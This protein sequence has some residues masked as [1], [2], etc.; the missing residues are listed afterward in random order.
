MVE[1][2]FSL[3]QEA[4]QEL[5]IDQPVLNI[6]SHPDNDVELVGSSIKV[7]HVT[8]HLEDGFFRGILIDPEA[9]IRVDG[10]LI[11]DTQFKIEPSQS[12]KIGNYIIFIQAKSD[13]SGMRVMYYQE[14]GQDDWDETGSSSYQDRSIL[15]NPVSDEITIDVEQSAYFEC[16]L[17]NA[18]PI[19]ATFFLRVNGV[20]SEWVEITP[21][22]INL[23]EG[24]R[25]LVQVRVT[26]PRDSSS[27]AGI[28]PVRVV[29]ISPNYVGQ[30]D[31]AT[32]TLTIQPFYEFTL[33]NLSPRD[34]RIGWRKRSGVTYLPIIN[35]S[36]DS[37]E[38]N[39]LAM[40]DEN[41]CSFDFWISEELQLNRQATTRLDAGETTELPIQVTP[42]KIP[43]FSLRNKRYHY[44]TNVQIPQRASAPQALSGSATAVPLFG[45]WSIVLGVATLLLGLF[46]L[47]QPNIRSFDVAAGKDVIE[48]GDSTKLIWD[49]SPFAT[50]L[51]VSGVDTP[52][53]RGQVSLTVA[54]TQSTNYELVSG[55]WLSGMFGLDQKRTV[56]VLVVP[57]TPQVNVFEVDKTI[58]A[59]GTPINVRWSVIEADEALL[60]IDGVVYTLSKEEFSGEQQVVLEKDALVTLEAK[61]ASGSELLSYFVNV[62]PPFI[63]IRSFTVW[64]K[65]DGVAQDAGNFTVARSITV[66]PRVKLLPIPVEDQAPDPN[67]PVK[68]VE[69]VPEPTSET[70]YRVEFTGAVREELQ[71]GEQVILEWDVDGVDSLQ[72]SPF[73]EELPARGNQPFFP[74]ES[75]NFVMTAASGELEG[76]YMLPVKVFDGEPPKAPTIDFF[77]ASPASMVGPGEVE[78]SWSVSGEWTRVNLSNANGILADYLNPVGFKKLTIKESSTIILTAYN[79]TLSSAKDVQLT[80]DPALLPIGLYL[81]EDNLSSG[82]FDVNYDEDFVI[83][84]YDPVLTTNPTDPNTFVEPTVDPTGTVYVTDG[85]NVCEIK[86]PLKVCNLVFKTP[87]SPKNVTASYS[88]DSVYQSA[89]T[90]DAYS[91]I[92]ILSSSVTLSPT[93]YLGPTPTPGSTILPRDYNGFALDTVMTA[94]IKVTSLRAPLPD[95]PGEV[96]MYFCKQTG[97]SITNWALDRPTCTPQTYG[98]IDPVTKTATITLPPFPAVGKYAL[99]F[100]YNAAGFEPA[101]VVEFDVDVNPIGIYFSLDKCSDPIAWTGCEIG[102]SD[103]AKTIIEFDVYRTDPA[104]VRLSDQIVLPKKEAYEFSENLS[105]TIQP[106]NCEF[107]VTS[108]GGSNYRIYRC[109][110]NF[111]SPSVR[112]T[113]TVDF[114]FDPLKDP[115]YS[116]TPSTQ[117]MSIL[118]IKESTRVSF[119]GSVF[120]GLKVGQKIDFTP[121]NT[122]GK[123]VKL[124]LDNDPPTNIAPTSGA[125]TITSSV[126]NTF[127]GPATGAC[128]VSN[129]GKTV[130]ISTP[131]TNCN[132]SIYLNNVVSGTLSVAYAGNSQ[133]YKSVSDPTLPQAISVTQQDQLETNW[134]Y[135][136]LTSTSYVS[137]GALD[138]VVNDS[139]L[140]VRIELLLPANFEKASLTGLDMRIQL[141]GTAGSGCVLTSDQAGGIS[142]IHLPTTGNPYFDYV[143][144]CPASVVNKSVTMTASL[145]NNTTKFALKSGTVLARTLQVKDRSYT[146]MDVTFTRVNGSESIYSGSSMADLHFGEVYD[147][148]A[149]VGLV[150]GDDWLGSR[151]VVLDNLVNAGQYVNIKFSSN[152]F[153]QIDWSSTTCVNRNSA[154]ANTV[155]VL[156]NAYTVVNYWGVPDINQPGISDSHFYSTSPCKIV[157]NGPPN[158]EV[159]SGGTTTLSYAITFNKTVGPLSTKL[160]KQTV[161]F[162]ATPTNYTPFVDSP[163]KDFV[164]EFKPEIATTSKQPLQA[165]SQLAALMPSDCGNIAAA[166]SNLSSPTA[167]LTLTPQTPFPLTP[168]AGCLDVSSTYKILGS[169]TGNDYFQN[170]SFEIPIRVLKHN[171]DTKIEFKNTSGSWV[172]AGSLYPKNTALEFK[173]TVSRGADAFGSTP[174]PTGKVRVWLENAGVKLN[175]DATAPAGQI[176]YTIALVAGSVSYN[177]TN[178][179]YE[180]T[181]TGLESV[182]TLTVNK[183]FPN[184]NLVYQYVGDTYYFGK[185]IQETMSFQ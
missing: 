2:D 19:V 29:A 78:F 85:A 104:G 165:L 117:T 177:S 183:N 143:L 21:E 129:I 184:I 139:D 137:W 149:T 37:A 69:L 3:D 158:T 151:K 174:D 24:Q 99:L 41:G 4:V 32:L 114:A 152:I 118:I 159:L 131:T 51:S 115:N 135:K 178:N 147:V 12:L 88:G 55:N 93:F 11:R 128:S 141:S 35:Q 167:K 52:I 173:V 66:S 79:G 26:P 120:S 185:I 106:W 145:A 72:I 9:E 179:Y 170:G 112:T 116:V 155:G 164:L 50:R 48:L 153:N 34:Q 61:N 70:G 74:Q 63:N 76:I 46:I 80:V 136:P 47:L 94:D 14:Y 100:T 20:P 31:I 168:V 87:G 105:G 81:V 56:A 113:A 39:L 171:P 119:L 71:P 59:K 176:D 123:A 97:T 125:I 157:F 130:T 101:E 8:I 160:R 54:P 134:L 126:A 10:V 25:Q 107:V 75:M 142:D 110:A 124:T 103:R 92:S 15:I 89:S 28:H 150:Y 64:V 111:A 36:N 127:A 133:Y 86:L 90:L 95:P 42:H 140:P 60:T 161:N 84:F 108:S 96:K 43:M 146:F 53:S 83:R 132:G 23:N 16:E 18:G 27:S 166:F 7:F 1:R 138:S 22:T 73:T 172:P 82:F 154:S 5:I 33:G 122:A 180:I 65:P 121:V 77:K 57:P 109:E 102:T 6:G 68:F 62:I 182:F 58:V 17:I 67:F 163:P 175:G 49:V 38:F 44:T 13:F 30:R 40:D 144:R 169:Y 91:N 181:P 148:S 98:T 45:W 156:L 162:S